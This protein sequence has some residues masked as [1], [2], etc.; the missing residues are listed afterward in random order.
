MD[1]NDAFRCNCLLPIEVALRPNLHIRSHPGSTKSSISRVPPPET[2]WGF[3]GDNDHEV[4]IAV[5]ASIPA[6]SGTK[7]V[8]PFRVI[9]SDR[10]QLFLWV[11]D[12]Y[13]SL[14]RRLITFV[15]QRGPLPHEK[16]YSSAR[17]GRVAN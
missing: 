4:I 2:L 17:K 8:N 5:W 1:G 14:S 9:H 16:C 10:R 15:T 3:I 13:F 11:D 12:N 7:E 6:C